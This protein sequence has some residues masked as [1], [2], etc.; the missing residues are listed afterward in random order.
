MLGRVSGRCI[1]WKARRAGGAAGQERAGSS[2]MILSA[3]PADPLQIA[4]RVISSVYTASVPLNSSGTSRMHT[5]TFDSHV[6]PDSKDGREQRFLVLDGEPLTDTWV[7]FP[8]R[9]PGGPERLPDLNA[10][11]DYSTSL[12][13]QLPVGELLAKFQEVEVW[14]T[15][16]ILED[17]PDIEDHIERVSLHRSLPKRDSS[18]DVN[19]VDPKLFFPVTVDVQHWAKPFS[20]VQFF[21]AL[22]QV[23]SKHPT[24]RLDDEH[25]SIY[26]DIKELHASIN[27]LVEAHRLSLRDIILQTYAMLAA[28]VR[29][30]SLVSF[31]EFPPAFKTACQQ[32]LVYFIQFLSDMGIEAGLTHHFSLGFLGFSWKIQDIHMMLRKS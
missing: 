26:I 20:I 22:E 4:C 7:S 6:P 29:R 31:F 28:A 13:C 9:Y 16:D 2:V 1:S 25:R 14:F 3:G 32:Y 30:D 19:L 12:I 10:S 24:Y 8:H 18:E 21:D 23:V 5:I 11:S 15:P 17:H 27:D